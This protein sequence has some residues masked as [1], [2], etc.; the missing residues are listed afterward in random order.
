MAPTCLLNGDVK[1]LKTLNK[2]LTLLRFWLNTSNT[3]EIL[4]NIFFI[5]NKRED[6]WK[7]EIRMI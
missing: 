1:N 5:L 3:F 6:K 7:L 4:L 2:S